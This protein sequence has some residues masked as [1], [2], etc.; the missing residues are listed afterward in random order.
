MHEVKKDRICYRIDKQ[1][2]SEHHGQ[3]N[4]KGYN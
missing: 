2:E 1:T 3:F 4:S